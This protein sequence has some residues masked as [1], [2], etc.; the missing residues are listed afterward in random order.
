MKETGMYDYG[1]RF[2]MPDI[3]RWE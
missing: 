3:G 1:A 2:Y